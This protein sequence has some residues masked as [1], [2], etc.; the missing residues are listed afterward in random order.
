[1]KK[2]KVELSEAEVRKV[3]EE[4]KPASMTQL[5]HEFGYRGSV[6]STL[7]KKFR[8]LIPNINALLKGS[9]EPAKGETHGGTAKTAEPKASKAPKAKSKPAPKASK[10][11]RDPRNPFREGSAYATCFDILAAHKDGL[12]KEKLVELLAKST[13]KDLVHSGY[14]CQVLMSAH[15]NENGLSNNDSPRHR[16]CRPGFWIKRT[17]GHAQLMV[18]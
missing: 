4:R 15:P 14:D 18:D 17:N 7:T 16:S 6:S 3:I 11:P 8:Q 9:A 13:G 1:V 2:A 5:A 12:P 10:Y